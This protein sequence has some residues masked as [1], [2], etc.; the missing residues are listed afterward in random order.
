MYTFLL[1]FALFT[2]FLFT[3][4]T[5]SLLNV[6][7]QVNPDSNVVLV[8]HGGAGSIQEGSIPPEREAAYREKLEE[9][10]RAGYDILSQGGSS[11]DA[12]ESA[13]QIL[14]ESPL[15]NAGRGAVLTNEGTAELDA[16]IMDGR[17]LQAGAVASIKHVKSPIELA[18]LVMTESPHVLL[19]GEGAEVFAREQGV[20]L[21]SNEYFLTQE[22][23]RQLERIKE[24]SVRENRS[25]DGYVEEEGI[26]KYGTVGAVALDRAGNL[27]AGTS[28]GGMMNKRFGR[29]GDSPIIGAGTYA[30]NETCG[31]SATGHGEY[32][33][34]GVIAYDI[35][36][37]MRYSGLSLVEAAHTVI[38]EKL[39]GMGG[40]GGVIA[41]DREGK[42]TMPFNT[43]GM[44]RG[45]IKEDGQIVV[46]FYRD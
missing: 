18:R 30:D 27:A 29:V 19:V 2:A 35:S 26:K 15:F 39:T 23:L 38:H 36:A 33:I 20:E 31:V 1:R 12:V 4:N 25:P 46:K 13:I 17:T 43:P 6:W 11:L 37:L 3:S 7:A 22:R 34:R 16:S 10:L 32:F 8:I 42:V 41:L 5:A 28:T 14:E 44:F 24:E 40:T 9:A 45:Y 21:V